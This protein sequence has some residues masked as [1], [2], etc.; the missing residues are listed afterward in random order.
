MLNSFNCLL[1]SFYLFYRRYVKIL[2]SLWEKR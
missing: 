1:K 2:E